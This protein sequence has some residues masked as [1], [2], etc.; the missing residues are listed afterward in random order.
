MKCAHSVIAYLE[1]LPDAFLT[2]SLQPLGL[3]KFW[4]RLIAK[5]IE[6]SQVKSVLRK[7]N[8]YL[9]VIS[10]TNLIQLTDAQK[11]LTHLLERLHKYQAS[12][13][14]AKTLDGSNKQTTKDKPKDKDSLLP[15][16]SDTVEFRRTVVSALSLEVQL[17][18]T[19]GEYDV[20]LDDVVPK[21]MAWAEHLENKDPA[22][23]RTH[24][25]K[26]FRQLYNCANKRA[27][28]STFTLRVFE[29]ALGCLLARRDAFFDAACRIA[30]HFFE[31]Q[32]KLMKSQCT[33]LPVSSCR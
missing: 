5:S 8:L 13:H 29:R 25:E 11:Y 2:K 3:E 7:Q 19:N 28:D 4:H 23:C 1:T 15:L 12:L 16:E 17:A 24:S 20:L 21:W 33:N 27:E 6:K 14:K 22:E 9:K 31:K 30:T 26:M 10:V 32:G 18:A